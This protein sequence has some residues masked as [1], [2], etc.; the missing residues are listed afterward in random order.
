MTKDH[1]DSTRAHVFADLRP[2]ICTFEV[3][4]CAAVTFPTRSIWSAHEIRHHRVRRILDCHFC[5]TTFTE[6]S[7]LTKHLRLVHDI[8]QHDC[9]LLVAL[10]LNKSTEA[11]TAEDKQCPLCLQKGLTDRSEFVTHLGH[12]LEEIALSVLPRQVEIG[13]DERCDDDQLVDTIHPQQLRPSQTTHSKT[14]SNAD[15][16]NL[17]IEP[18]SHVRAQAG[19]R[20]DRSSYPPRAEGRKSGLSDRQAAEYSFFRYTSEQG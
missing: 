20:H 11:L 14:Q 16:G 17:L 13:S 3:C 1:S 10:S 12:H 2:Y 7:L 6:D 15:E 18:L 19:E 4:W 9:E 8:L 5:S